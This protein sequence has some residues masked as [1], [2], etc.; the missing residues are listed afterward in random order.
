MMTT[1]SMTSMVKVML[2]EPPELLAH[3]VKVVSDKFT[4]GVP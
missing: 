2:A 4:E 3:I 1:G